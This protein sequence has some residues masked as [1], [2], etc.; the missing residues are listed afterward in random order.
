MVWLMLAVLALGQILPAAQ[1]QERTP[2]AGTPLLRNFGPADYGG[3][4]QNW[5]IVQDRRG[6]MYFGNAE[7]G[8]LEFDGAR[9]RRIAV[10]NRTA[11][12]ALGVDGSGRI[13]VGGTGEIGYL[14]PDATGLLEYRSLMDR[15]PEQARDFSDVWN[16]YATADGV[17]FCSYQ[18]II[19]IGKQGVR[20]WRA[21]FHKAFVI[22]DVLYVR[23][24]GRGLMKLENDAFRLLPQGERFADERVYAVL[25]WPPS[26]QKAR[27][28]SLL[29]G[30]HTQGWFL[31]DGRTLRPWATPTDAALKRDLL[32]QAIALADGRLAVATLQN[33]VLLLDAQGNLLHHLGQRTGLNSDMVYQMFQDRQGTLWLATDDGGIASV[34]VSAPVTFF[35]RNSGLEGITLS[36]LRHRGTLYAATT[37]GLYRLAGN[38]AEAP[39]F[40]AVPAVQGPALSFVDRGDDFLVSGLQG[41][42]EVRDGVATLVGPSAYGSPALLMSRLEP[43]R[44]FLGLQSGLASMRRQDGRWVDEGMVDGVADDVHSM[45]QLADGRLWLATATGAVRLQLDHDRKRGGALSAARIERFDEKHGVPPGY[46]HMVEIDGEL[47]FATARG[48]YRFEEKT[49]RFEADPRFDALF[50]G[51]VR[52]VYPVYQDRSGRV[53]MGTRDASGNVKEAGVAVLGNDGNYRWEPRPLRGIGDALIDAIYGDPDG[54]IWLGSENGLY[55]HDPARTMDYDRPF[56]ALVRNV[57]TRSGRLVFGGAGRVAAPELAYRENAL[58]FE[59]SAPSFGGQANRYQFQLEGVD[60]D[61]SPWIAEAFRDYTNLIE[62]SYRFRVRAMNAYGKVSGESM[63]A[64]AVSPPWYRTWLAY[65]TYATAVAAL[66]AG[67]SRWRSLALRRR[68]REL[69]DLVAAQTQALQSTNAALA[70]LSVTD[71]LTGLKNRRYLVDRIAEDVAAVRRACRAD[72]HGDVPACNYLLFVMVDMDCFKHVNDRYGHAAGDEVLKQFADILRG[73]CRETDTPVRW[74]GEEFLVLA[75]YAVRDAGPVIAERIRALTAAHTFVLDRGQLLQRTCSVGFA[76]FPL[77]PNAPQRFPWERVVDLADQCLY[78]I[79]RRGGNA[80]AGVRGL[81]TC[82][83]DNAFGADGDDL[84]AL[85]AGGCLELRTSS[86]LREPEE[87]LS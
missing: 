7:D 41:V 28:G 32:Y 37:Q 22:D 61:W 33:G 16:I 29:I 76:S 17:Y 35:G 26:E 47:R 25:P 45:H 65:L 63:Y 10:A 52:K 19:R 53:W 84:Q 44:I 79:K 30:T 9:W 40:V 24:V 8:V 75:R 72:V 59:V 71:A 54:L 15:I 55:R 11:V 51:G 48:V 60:E 27:A 68:N 38:R 74:G 58:R 69:A 66:L 50:G 81:D 56:R 49:A 12:T 62:G 77:L 57:S 39:R 18:R 87:A 80:W 64:F 85:L 42:F 46:N 13:Y 43:S 20:T 34:D 67:V 21:E 2:D 78:L 31:H 23:E 6:L 3:S 70:E 5:A 36:L 73:V 86:S 14:A 4:A 1:A 82:L 83:S